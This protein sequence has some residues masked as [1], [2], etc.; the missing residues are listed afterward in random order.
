VV[1]ERRV[2]NAIRNGGSGQNLMPA[3]LLD[4]EDARAVARFVAV[5]AGR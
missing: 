1:D 5:N 3:G 4:G 2:L